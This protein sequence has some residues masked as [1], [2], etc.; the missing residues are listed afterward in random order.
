MRFVLSLLV[1]ALAFPAAAQAYPDWRAP[2]DLG[3]A[4]EGVFRFPQAVAYDAS[5][6]P[7][8]D[9]QAPAGP[10]VYVADQFSFFVQKFTAT[11]GFVRRF[12]GYGS[13]P[14]HF[15]A[16]SASASP[17]SGIV[18][19]IAG[20]AVDDRGHVY[21]LDSFNS[22]I[23]RFSPGGEFE[24]Q[25][26]TFGSEPGQFDLGIHGGIAVSRRLPLR[27]RSEQQPRAAL[28]PRPGRASGRAT[29]GVRHRG[30][31]TRSVRPD[32]RLGRRPGARP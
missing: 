9:P 27:R 31:R 17:T 22:R 32:P 16:T 6:T 28:P 11:G 14:G 26:G 30:H 2:V 10:Y 23:A 18:G 12:G 19:G 8:P 20:V 29:A 4:Q 15:G 21:V 24:G 13:E 1:A 25:F 3:V 7:D 5:G